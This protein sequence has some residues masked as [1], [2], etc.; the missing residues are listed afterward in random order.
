MSN[1]L[2]TGGAGFIGKHLIKA[3]HSAG[4][5][6][7]VIDCLVEQVHGDN[8]P[9]FPEGV[10][11]HQWRVNDK[12]IGK[13]LEETDYVFHEAAMVGVGQSMYDIER[14]VDYTDKDTAALLQMIIEN[15]KRIKKIILAGSVSSFGEGAY[16]CKT[17]K[18]YHFPPV[19][20][21]VDNGFDYKGIVC[22]HDLEPVG[23]IESYPMRPGSVYG[24]SKRNQEE[25]VR[26]VCQ[27]NNIP[28]VSLRYFNVCGEGQSLRN[29]YTGIAVSF[30]NQIRQN[31]PVIIFEDGEQ[32]RDFISV[33]D[34]VSA[35]I[36]AMESDSIGVFNIGTG[37]ATKLIDFAK[38][39][40]EKMIEKG[41]ISSPPELVITKQ[42]RYGDTRHLFADIS[43]AKKKLLFSPKKNIG[44]IIDG[45]IEWGLTQH[46]STDNSISYNELQ[47]RGL[48][49]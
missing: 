10:I 18:S 5:N 33:H 4:H 13:L 29:P 11:F 38:K 46:D 30:F 40:G 28:W 22:S 49:K 43:K 47:E 12:R 7:V 31:K 36:K 16:Y 3:L 20:E 25:L 34:I 44:D 35:N 17:C 21:N 23:L 15:K 19:R 1:V 14:Y 9:V 37:E 6:V 26:I 42:Y 8:K 45:I 41:I 32:I 2:V 24:Q 27:A 39:M 48:L